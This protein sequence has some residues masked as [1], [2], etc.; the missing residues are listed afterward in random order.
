MKILYFLTYCKYKYR[1]IPRKVAV[2]GAWVLDTKVCHTYSSMLFHFEQASWPLFRAE[3]TLLC[4]EGQGLD[5]ESIFSVWVH[6]SSVVSDSL[7]PHRLQHARPP[8]PSPT[9]E[10]TQTHAHWVSDAI[11]PFHPLSSPSPPTFS[12]S[13][14]QGLFKWVSSLHQ[15]AR[16]LAFQ[17]QH[18]SFQCIFR[19]DFFKMDWFDLHAAQGTLKSLLQHHSS[20]PSILRY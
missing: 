15:V 2:F 18:Q 10:F 9:S 3:I 16:V 5:K 14:H 12:L 20:K 11:Q 8:C 6:F 19:T 13:Q 17:L 7:Q 1:L 4:M